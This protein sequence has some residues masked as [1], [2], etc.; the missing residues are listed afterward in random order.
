M[1]GPPCSGSAP[2]PPTP[3]VSTPVD[4]RKDELRLPPYVT[5][6]ASPNPASR[7]DPGRS[8][9]PGYRPEPGSTNTRWA[10]RSSGGESQQVLPNRGRSRL[11]AAEASPPR[12]SSGKPPRLPEHVEPLGPLSRLSIIPA[13]A[14]SPGRPF[15]ADDAGSMPV[16]RSLGRC[17]SAGRR[18]LSHRRLC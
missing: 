3:G 15:Q 17:Y 2:L 11:G 10:A 18:C 9:F 4:D 12:P 13:Q 5:P 7:S 1:L 14:D 6:P 16:G 8:Q